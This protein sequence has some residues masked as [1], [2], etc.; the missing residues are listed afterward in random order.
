MQVSMNIVESRP[1]AEECVSDGYLKTW[2]SIPPT[3][4]ASLCAFVCRIV[5][6]LSINR[7]RD[8]KAERR[9]KDLTLSLE[10]LEA[11]ISVDESHADILPGL[12][13]SFLEG[14]EEIDRK[15]FMG[16][17]FHATPVK[18]LAQTYDMTPNAVS[19]RL[20]KTRE[21][22]RLHLEEGGYSV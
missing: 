4:P 22:L 6:N 9:N 15:L 12:I 17:Y 1:D 18:D 7:L 8:M 2:H 5:R 20:H 21:K 3:R 13:S 19:L 10:E 16:R 14:L 11:C